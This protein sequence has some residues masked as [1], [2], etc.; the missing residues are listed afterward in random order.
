MDVIRTVLQ[1]KNIFFTGDAGTGKS[2]ILMLIIE[3]VPERGT[4]ITAWTGAA[5][6]KIGGQTFLSFMGIGL[7]D[8]TRENLLKK[9]G[10]AGRRNL[11]TADLLIIDEVS[12]LNADIFDKAEWIARQIRN[13]EEPFGGIQLVLAGDFYQ[14][15]PVKS[16][17][18]LFESSRWDACIPV[19][20]ELDEIFRQSEEKL[21]T[22]LNEIRHDRCT[23][24]TLELI[25][26]LKRELEF[27]D[28][29]LPVEIY[30]TNVDVDRINTKRLALLAGDE[31]KFCSDD[32]GKP[33]LLKDCLRPETLVLKIGAMVMHLENDRED[34]RLVNGSQGVVE[35]FIN[36]LPYVRFDEG[37]EKLIDYT[38]WKKEVKGK[39]LATRSQLPIKLSWAM[40]GHRCQGMSIARLKIKCDDA[41]DYGIA[42]VMFSRA[43][44]L[45]G[46]QVM[47][48]DQ[49]K[50]QVNPKVRR[51]YKKIR[52]AQLKE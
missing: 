48:F 3:S 6:T 4:F 20:I 18:L 40:T 36:G 19:V 46:L 1:K 43:R 7:G 47:G 37:S 27:D 16:T 39:T 26:S 12:M 38:V 21:I 45:A 2:K 22:M 34:R 10:F 33:E 52:A 8:D 51:F 41:F 17:R 44:T 9:I 35:K 15:P 30:C 49:S 5:A 42:Y 29:I 28:G 25:E 31:V 14:I 13:C 23:P 11:Q 50:F 24:A 32:T